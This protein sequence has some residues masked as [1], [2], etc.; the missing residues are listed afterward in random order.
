MLLWCFICVLA[1][2]QTQQFFFLLLL[3]SFLLLFFFFFFCVCGLNYPLL[4]DSFMVW[5]VTVYTRSLPRH[6][7]ELNPGL[8]DSA[9]WE[10]T[11]FCHTPNADMNHGIFHVNSY[12]YIYDLMRACALEEGSGTR[13]G[14]YK[15]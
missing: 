4:L 6:F 11:C 14:Q 5:A 13:A 7:K 2:W 8:G 1:E 12:I 3:L 10:C 15:C 9:C